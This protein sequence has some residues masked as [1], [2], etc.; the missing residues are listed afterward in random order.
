M[1]CTWTDVYEQI[2]RRPMQI[3]FMILPIEK[4]AVCF[5]SIGVSVLYFVLFCLSLSKY[6]PY[7]AG[8]VGTRRL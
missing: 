7:S 3:L 5:V 8:L 4:I 1:F 6:G 2:S